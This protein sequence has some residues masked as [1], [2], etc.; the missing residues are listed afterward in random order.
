MGE[1]WSIPS[2]CACVAVGSM[3]CSRVVGAKF[4]STDSI[5]A[6]LHRI[7]GWSTLLNL[8]QNCLECAWEALISALC[9]LCRRLF[10]GIWSWRHLQR[11]FLQR[12]WMSQLLL[13]FLYSVRSIHF[14]VALRCASRGLFGPMMKY[15]CLV[16]KRK[17]F[18]LRCLIAAW[19]FSRARLSIERSA[20][21]VFAK[22][23]GLHLLSVHSEIVDFC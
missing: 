14:Y 21:T 6:G 8:E 15:F 12:L 2:L 5:F 11:P 7:P 20:V 3:N 4:T 16:A 19:W 13:A 23:A 9:Y 1:N 17:F 18:D 10:G 22:C